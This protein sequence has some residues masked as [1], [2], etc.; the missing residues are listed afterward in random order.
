MAPFSVGEKKVG[1]DSVGE[2][3]GQGSSKEAIASDHGA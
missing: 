3:Y 1:S 2:C